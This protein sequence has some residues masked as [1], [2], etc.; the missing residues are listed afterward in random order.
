MRA[1]IVTAAGQGTRLGYNIPKALVCVREKTL[2]SY[3]VGLFVK[4]K[5][6]DFVVVTAPGDACEEFADVLRCDGYVCHVIEDVKNFTV[7]KY[8]T[9]ESIPVFVCAGGRSRQESV[10]HGLE[11]CKESVYVYV[12]DAARP[13][14]PL[15]VL[16]RLESALCAGISAAIPVMPVTDTIKQ[17]SSRVDGHEWEEVTATVSRDFLRSVQTPQA[18]STEVLRNVH[19]KYK[20][21]ADDETIS[22]TDDASLIEQAGGKVIA[23]QGSEFSMKITRPLDMVVAEYIAER[24]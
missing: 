9:S 19:Q 22:A 4:S 10:A 8:R 24:M 21:T 13:F 12:H 23:V 14:V 16:Q 17:V 2:L 6:C 1:A 11:L 20:D 5:I 15:S 7:H 3:S 18:F